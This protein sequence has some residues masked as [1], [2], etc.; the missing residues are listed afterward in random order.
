[1][2]LIAEPVDVWEAVIEDRP[3]A[4]ADTLSLLR[5]AGA[6][7]QF[8]TARRSPER[9][10]KGV[11]FVAPLCGDREIAAA[12][13]AGFNVAQSL[14]SVR[15]MGRDRPGLA[16]LLTGRL[17]TAGI[18]LRG[19]SASTVGSQFAVYLALDSYGDVEKTLSVLQEI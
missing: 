2:E 14:H 15:V 1:M 13:E 12:A 9:A 6:D 5:E 10:S 16:A 11:V 19:F 17:A 4:L 18:N 3:G 8:I 7:L